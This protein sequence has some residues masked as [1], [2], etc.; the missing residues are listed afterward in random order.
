MHVEIRGQLE[1]VS[2]FLLECR[3]RNQTLVSK[4]DG[5]CPNS[6]SHL[7]FFLETKQNT[8]CIGA[9]MEKA[10]FYF[11]ITSLTQKTY[12]RKN[13]QNSQF[14]RPIH[15]CTSEQI[16]SPLIII[17]AQISKK[18]NTH[19]SKTLTQRLGPRQSTNTKPLLV[20]QRL[21]FLAHKRSQQY[22]LQCKSELV[23]QAM[24]LCAAT[25]QQE[26]SELRER[27]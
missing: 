14:V 23:L 3:T 11:K 20:T 4:L 13:F 18:M 17:M 9:I 16:N 22:W 8:T 1:G 19:S 7:V 24:N 25:R 15:V 2:S 6:I 5:K 21:S 26:V 27:N 10:I 12:L